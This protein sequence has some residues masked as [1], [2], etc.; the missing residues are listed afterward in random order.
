METW[1][2]SWR[3][4]SWFSLLGEAVCWLAEKVVCQFDPRRQYP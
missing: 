3:S 2:S 4:L 1:P